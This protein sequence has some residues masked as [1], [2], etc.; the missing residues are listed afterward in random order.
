[1]Q[2]KLCIHNFG[3]YFTEKFITVIT[4]VHKNVKT[5]V[6]IHFLAELILWL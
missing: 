1:M 6:V 5:N 3:M 2:I 4:E